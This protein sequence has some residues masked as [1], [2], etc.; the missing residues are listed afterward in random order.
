MKCLDFN[1]N[2]YAYCKKD[3]SDSDMITSHFY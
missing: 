2:S 1:I 3:E